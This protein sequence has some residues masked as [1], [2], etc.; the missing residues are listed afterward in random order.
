MHLLISASVCFDWTAWLSIWRRQSARGWLSCL[1]GKD[2]RL[3]SYLTKRLHNPTT[4]QSTTSAPRTASTLLQQQSSTKVTLL[5]W[6]R[7]TE[8]ERVILI[9]LSVWNTF[10]IKKRKIWAGLSL[11]KSILTQVFSCCIFISSCVQFEAAAQRSVIML[12]TF[13][14]VCLT[15][16]FWP[17]KP[18]KNPTYGWKLPRVLHDY[19]SA[20]AKIWRGVN[21]FLY[22]RRPSEVLHVGTS[23]LIGPSSV[24]FRCFYYFNT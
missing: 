12:V 7:E 2:S 11:L 9:N 15:L 4:I 1:L 13:M 23:S 21:Q 18:F 17:W 24:L 20:A 8:R 6:Y 5:Q 19:K 22:K 14:S 16:C 3:Y 10:K